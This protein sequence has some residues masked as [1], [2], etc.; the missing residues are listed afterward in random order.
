M[1]ARGELIEIR[2][3]D[4]RFSPAE[5]AGLVSAVSQVAAGPDVVD[6]LVDRTE[7]ALPALI[8]CSPLE[9]VRWNHE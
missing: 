5:A 7:G 3:T 4:L 8:S 2:A 6:P 9:V 1:R